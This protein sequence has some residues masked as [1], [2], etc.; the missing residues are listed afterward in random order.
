MYTA[1]TALFVLLQIYRKI[2][3][4]VVLSDCK[5]WPV[6]MIERVGVFE[7]KMLRHLKETKRIR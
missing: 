3:L 6:T 5:T 7:D 4:R 2:V 1:V